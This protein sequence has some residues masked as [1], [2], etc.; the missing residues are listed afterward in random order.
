MEKT[1]RVHPDGEPL[2]FASSS[3]LRGRETRVGCLIC[4]RTQSPDQGARD[5]KLFYPNLGSQVVHAMKAALERPYGCAEQTLSSTYTSLLYLELA[6][7][8]K[9]SGARLD[10]DV[11]GEAKDYLQL[12]YT[13]LK[14]YFDASGGLT[15]WGGNDHSPDAALTAYGIEFLTEATPYLDIDHEQIHSA[16]DWLVRNQQPDGSWRPH[17]GE[18]GAEE[19]LYIAV[20]LS[21]GL[22]DKDLSEDLR[23]RT[24]A[25]IASATAW[26]TSSAAALHDP[27]AN[28]LR[29]LLHAK[30]ADALRGD[31]AE[32]AV[33]DRDGLHWSERSYS[34][35]YGWGRAGD[36][37]TTATVLLALEQRGT[38]HGKLQDDALLYLLAGKDQYGVWLSGQ[39]TVRVL[40]ALLP[41]ATAQLRGNVQAQ[42][43][44]LSI[45][46][47]A[48]A[49]AD[50]AALQFNPKI[51]GAPRSLD[52]SEKLKPGHNELLFTGSDEAS[53]ASV[54]T[55]A[56]V[57]VPWGDRSYEKATQTSK[58]AG[59]DF[60]YA[61]AATGGAV[62]TPIECTVDARRFG[63]QSY[64]MLLATVG[65]PP[66][67][68]V[69]RAP[70]SKLIDAG[71]IS[72]YELQPDRIV[73]YLWPW[74]AEGLHFA[75]R[76]TPRYAVQA[77]GAAP[78]KLEDYYNPDL[79]VVLAPQTLLSF[80]RPFTTSR[81]AVFPVPRSYSHD[82]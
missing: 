33:R 37:E 59:L 16:M 42:Q 45:N 1:I 39:A 46:G 40:K 73:F 23:K 63:S 27:Y 74:R 21:A 11:E 14:D 8:A 82:L 36:I 34:P 31:L 55:A 69:D 65:L 79:N 50:A 57:Y 17:Y 62:G 7:A 44:G 18:T 60:G 41:L 32:T 6:K 71:T 52:L 78:A 61:C 54:S 24:A 75:F 67:A 48:I 68:D 10:A 35:F 9:D 13:R 80:H 56:E 47:Q 38:Q 70:L 28:A 81:V 19:N 29:L 66:G 12:G 26:A 5:V 49:G 64:G 58:D 76:F 53:L 20:A 77:K 30:N 22:E 25:S 4:L 15:Y 2:S 72:R 43:I 51:L 3:L